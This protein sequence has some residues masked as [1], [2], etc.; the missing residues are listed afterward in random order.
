MIEKFVVDNIEF[1]LACYNLGH[2]MYY[3]LKSKGLCKVFK[4]RLEALEY[5]KFW[6]GVK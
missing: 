3:Q 4:T 5:A 6:V 2:S 1:Q